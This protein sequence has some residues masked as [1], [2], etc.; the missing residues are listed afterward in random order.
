MS[1]TSDS[2]DIIEKWPIL[3]A[4]PVL[5]QAI[6]A[7]KQGIIVRDEYFLKKITRCYS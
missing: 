2:K 3:E 6:T 7:I 4:I 1:I 5:Q